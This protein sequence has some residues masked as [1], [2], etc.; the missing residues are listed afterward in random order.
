MT[1]FLRVAGTAF[2]IAAVIGFFYTLPMAPL[3]AAFFGLVL[4]GIGEL[5]NRAKKP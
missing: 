1:L 4:V 3:A 2:L 5:L